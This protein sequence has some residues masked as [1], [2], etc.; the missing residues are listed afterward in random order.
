MSRSRLTVTVDETHKLLIARYSGLM[1]GA[2]IVTHLVDQAER[3]HE[4]WT[5]DHI[6]DTRRHDGVMLMTDMDTLAKRWARLA[7]G[8]DAGCMSAMISADPLNYARQSQRQ[9][10][11]PG[12]IMG[13]FAT[14]DEGLEWIK[15]VRGYNQRATSLSNSVSL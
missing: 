12:R 11:F 3:I 15:T 7:E 2:E 8:R 5:Y 4:P 14:F 9:V 6:F 13:V 10:L 1:S